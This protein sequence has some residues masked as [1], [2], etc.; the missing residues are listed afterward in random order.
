MPLAANRPHDQLTWIGGFVYSWGRGLSLGRSGHAPRPLGRITIDSEGIEITF[1]AAAP[2]A[3]EIFKRVGNRIAWSDVERIQAFRGFVPI[4]GN[5]GVK[6]Y[7]ARR[8]I[9]RCSPSARDEILQ[10]ARPFVPP[11]VPIDTHAR[12]VLPG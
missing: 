9:F 2:F 8:L 5:V 6:F 7:G 1:R 4:P 11:T 12:Y 3:N 10:A